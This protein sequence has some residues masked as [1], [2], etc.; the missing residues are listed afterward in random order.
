MS[1]L[2]SDPKPR[3]KRRYTM[4]PAALEARRAN[5]RHSTGP[6]TEAGKAK[7]SR[8]AWVHGLYSGAQAQLTAQQWG[9]V[10]M[11]GKPCRRTCQYH[12]DNA[13]CQAPCT[14]VMEGHTQAGGDCLDKTV[15]LT[16]FDRLLTAMRT[17]SVDGMHELLSAE[18]A[19]AM[20]IL[21][22]LRQDIAEQGL[23]VVIPAISKDGEVIM[24]PAT[25]DAVPGRVVA[26]PALIQYGNLLDKLGIN[27]AALMATPRAIAD[28]DAQEDSSAALSALLGNAF[29][30]LGD[31]PGGHLLEHDTDADA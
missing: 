23:T 11:L 22:R 24:H 18:A 21:V 8:N 17:G 5:A 1:D 4:S 12:P 27:L 26:N 14:L 28:V 30:N 15:Y 31:A 9:S 29:R 3:P 16:A 25:G 13:A 10:S 19:G 7:S 2:P 20:E 6:R